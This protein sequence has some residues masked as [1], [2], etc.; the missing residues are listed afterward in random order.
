MPQAL[1][2][3]QTSLTLAHRLVRVLD[4]VVPTYYIMD[5]EKTMPETVAA[6]NGE[7]VRH[8]VYE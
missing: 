8:A 7:L 1:E 4:A 2:P 6:P 3:L 5:L